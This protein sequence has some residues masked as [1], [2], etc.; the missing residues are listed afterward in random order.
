MGDREG[1]QEKAAAS[2][3]EVPPSHKAKTNTSIF[4]VGYTSHSGDQLRSVL[5]RHFGA[6]SYDLVAKN[7]NSFTDCALAF[8]LSRRLPKKYSS[9]ETL[10]TSMPNVLSFASCYCYKTN[11]GAFDVDKVIMQIDENA[12]KGTAEDEYRRL[13]PI[14]Y[15][16]PL[17]LLR[18]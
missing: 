5:S 17:S 1:V 3:E 8:L 13:L 14:D 6:G 4:P 16:R 7:C 15:S 9:V 11:P 2:R 12:G 10:G 18:R